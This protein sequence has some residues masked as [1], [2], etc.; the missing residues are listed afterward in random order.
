MQLLAGAMGLILNGSLRDAVVFPL[1]SRQGPG[2]IKRRD[3]HMV[4]KGGEMT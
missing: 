3:K 2:E 4:W 1:R